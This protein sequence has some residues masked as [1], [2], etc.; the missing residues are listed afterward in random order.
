MGRPLASKPGREV[1]KQFRVFGVLLLLAGGVLAGCLASEKTGEAS[2]EEAPARRAQIDRPAPDLA[3]ADSSAHTI[4]LYRGQDERRLPILVLGSGEQLTLEFDLLAEQGRPLSVYF[5]HADRQWRRDLSPIDYLDSFRKDNLLDYDRARAVSLPYVH[6]TYGFPNKSIDFLVSGNYIVRV[7]E[8]GDED[9]VLFERPF[10]I[11]ESAGT[12]E[13]G[14]GQTLAGSQSGRADRPVALYR[15]PG[16]LGSNPFDY[17]TCFMPSGAL[18]QVRC[19]ARAQLAQQPQLQFELPLREG[20]ASSGTAG[21]FLDLS[22]F[23]P[24]GEIVRIDRTTTPY[25][26]ILEADDALFAGSSAAEPLSGQLVVRDA[27]T[28]VADPETAAEYAAVR[29]RFTPPGGRPLGAEVRVAGS[30]N[31]GSLDG[32]PRLRWKAG[33]GRYVGTVLL[34]QGL[35]EYRYVSPDARLAEVFDQSLPPYRRRYLTFVYYNDVSEG[36]DRLLAVREAQ[37]Q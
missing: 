32:A 27:V 33:Q 30:F 4:Q 23:R 29:F 10:Y 37:A 34:K 9:E 3:P 25:E 24:G 14:V 21:Y 31:G 12:L 28:D 7:T 1:R 5:Y 20:F 6:Y 22:A 17:T 15:P 26:V 11:S 16:S 18:Q 2:G 35:Y 13:V 36:T 8:Q 19:S